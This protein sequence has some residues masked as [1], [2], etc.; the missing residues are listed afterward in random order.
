[1]NRSRAPATWSRSRPSSS[2][3]AQTRTAL[4]AW[5]SPR[6][7]SVKVRPCSVRTGRASAPTSTRSGTRSASLQTRGAHP[8]RP[9]PGTLGQRRWVRP[10]H[11]DWRVHGERQLLIQDALERAE[12]FEV[13]R[14]CVGDHD[15]VGTD[16]LP[17]AGDLTRQVG[18]GFDDQRLGLRRRLEDGERHPHQVVQVRPRGVGDVPGPQ[19]CREHLLR[20]RLA[21][22]PRDGDDGSGDPGPARP[23]ERAEGAQGVGHLQQWQPGHR[24]CPRAYHCG[25]GAG[26]GGGREEVV[27]IEALARQ[28]HEQR[29]LWNG[30]RIGRDGGECPAVPASRQS[31]RLADVALGP[32]RRGRRLAARVHRITALRTIS[33]SSKGTF[34]VPRIW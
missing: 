15:D 23:R 26:G 3:T 28:R 5:C 32:G 27:G 9:P 4:S 30:P 31:Q 14:D 29:A 34:S 1:M 7:A 22:R 17:I 21:V 18:A 8:L 19:R 25:A 20:A 11:R 6:A 16:D 33:R 2:A 13:S 12:A 10:D 24:R